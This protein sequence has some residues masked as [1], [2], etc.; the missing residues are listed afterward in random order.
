[1]NWQVEQS[2]YAESIRPQG[3][4]WGL[5]LMIDLQFPAKFNIYLMKY[6]IRH[7]ET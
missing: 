3:S 4:F 5:I 2:R 7:I 6:V 1:M